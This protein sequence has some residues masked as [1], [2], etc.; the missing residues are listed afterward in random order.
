MFQ[1]CRFFFLTTRRTQPSALP[2]GLGRFGGRRVRCAHH[3]AP[4][5][6][7]A[8]QNVLAQ[9]GGRARLQA[10]ARLHQRKA[11]HSTS[12]RPPPGNGGQYKTWTLPSQMQSDLFLP[13]H[14]KPRNRQLRKPLVVQVGGRASAHRC[15]WVQFAG[16]RLLCS[17]LTCVC[18][19]CSEHSFPGPLETLRSTSAPSPSCPTRL[20]QVC[21]STDRKGPGLQQLLTDDVADFN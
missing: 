6:H 2:A 7:A 15:T 3:A 12:R 1:K 14:R 13:R 8:Q 5:Q 19:V 10:A 16:G 21:T 4:E 18:P 20:Q 9:Q 11:A 17:P